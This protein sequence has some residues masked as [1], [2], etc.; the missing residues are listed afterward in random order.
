MYSCI[1]KY[2]GLILFQQSSTLIIMLSTRL[3]SST[4]YI[5]ATG[6]LVLSLFS[7]SQA[8]ELEQFEEKVTE[9]T[10]DNGL[11]FLVIERH[12]APV[13]SF[14][15]FVD[16]G[17]ANE[18]AGNTG[19]AHIFEHMAFK[20]THYIGTANWE[21]EKPLID[22]MDDTY[23]QWVRT[24]NRPQ[25]DSTRIDSLWSRFKSLQEEAGQYVENNEFAQIIDVH[26]GT[27]L[28][29]GTGAD[30]T[31][32]FYS[33]PENKIELWFSLES[34]RFKNPVFREFYKEKQVI[35]EERRRRVE[36][37]PVGRLIEEMISVS[38]NTFP[39]GHPIIGWQSDIEAT[40]IEDT[41]EFFNTHY[42]PGNMTIAIAGDVDPD[43]VKQLA[44]TYF[45]DLE[46]G[47]PAPQVTTEEPPQRGERRFVIEGESQPF[48]LMGYHTVNMHHP[49][50]KPLQLLGSIISGGRTSRLY[51]RLVEEEEKA[52]QVIA[53]NGYPGTKF[54]SLFI[55]FAVPNRGVS[56]SEVEKL[57]LDEIEKVKNGAI[58]KEE[59]QRAKTNA[60]AN[61]IRGLD[62]NSGLA[63][64][65]AAAE[66]QQ[67]D[68]RAV[69]TELEELQQVTLDDL[70]RVAQKYFTK[71]N[72]TVG[73]LENAEQDST[74]SSAPAN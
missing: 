52:L 21:E 66:A 18:P 26:G 58:T 39:Y 32:Y 67:G 40:T 62:S 7:G 1:Y 27:G 19:I 12:L 20:G 53:F 69:F 14:V 25:T 31:V 63:Q 45:G 43:H 51:K 28:N 15:T 61:L 47:E 60:R 30:Q 22:K 56:P 29:A 34:D 10:L 4:L 74:A 49:D 23:Q 68:W 48:Y 71:Q 36:S 42:V 44:K 16:V 13:A 46:P 55:T 5:L 73:I 50:A 17:A 2:A 24:R 9:F 8:Q 35:L 3:K 65:F 33:L 38:Y 54:E 59:L 6:F 41:R 37:S 11:T 64:R 57:V 72:R 70:Q